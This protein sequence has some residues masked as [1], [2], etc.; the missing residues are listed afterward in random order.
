[1]EGSP[2]NGGDDS[3]QGFLLLPT[4]VFLTMFSG[5]CQ[6]AQNDLANEYYHVLATVSINNRIKMPGGEY[7]EAC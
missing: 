5:V 1:M 7:G 6:P 2:V 3:A 4:V